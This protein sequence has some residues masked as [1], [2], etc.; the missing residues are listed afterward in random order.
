MGVDINL[1]GQGWQRKTIKKMA[2]FPKL[3]KFDL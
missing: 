1:L 3:Q 2:V